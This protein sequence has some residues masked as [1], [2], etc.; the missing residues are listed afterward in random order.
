MPARPNSSRF[1]PVDYYTNYYMNCPSSIR[2]VLRHPAGSLPHRASFRAR[3]R[4][5]GLLG[6]HG[7]PALRLT[8]GRFAFENAGSNSLSASG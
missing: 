5:N 6:C 1:R 8:D 7:P 4:N 2:P 3:P